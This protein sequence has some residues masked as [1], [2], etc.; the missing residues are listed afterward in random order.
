M[1][2]ERGLSVAVFRFPWVM[3]EPPVE[4]WLQYW[5]TRDGPLE[6]MGS[7]LF[8]DDAAR[9]YILALEHPTPGFEA[10][11]FVASDVSS[12]VP[13]RQ[14]LAKYHPDF[15]SLPPDWPDF[16]CPVD[17]AKAADHFGWHPQFSIQQHLQ[18]WRARNQ[19]QAD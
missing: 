2:E 16:K 15:P 13:L 12:A 6:G 18:Q 7:Y 9:A 5:E 3:I 8:S 1:A 11:H 19:K 10:Y 14:R 17:C 4:H